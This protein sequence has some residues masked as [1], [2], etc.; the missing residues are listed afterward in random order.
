M[1]LRDHALDEGDAL[2]RFRLCPVLAIDKEGSLHLGPFQEIQGLTGIFGWSI[3]KR[4]RK[5]SAFGAAADDLSVKGHRPSCCVP[6]TQS[7][8]YIADGLLKSFSGGVG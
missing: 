3:I 2:R 8:G 7:Q 5:G 4:Q 6:T 1:A